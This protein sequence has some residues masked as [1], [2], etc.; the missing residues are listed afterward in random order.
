MLSMNLKQTT[1]HYC[2]P[3]KGWKQ[4]TVYRGQPGASERRDLPKYLK[5]YFKSVAFGVPQIDKGYT[6]H[7]QKVHIFYA[8]HPLYLQLPVYGNKIGC[9]KIKGNSNNF[10]K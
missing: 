8:P 3:Q 5:P 6:T 9:E 7:K 2:Y 10:D 4:G 1:F